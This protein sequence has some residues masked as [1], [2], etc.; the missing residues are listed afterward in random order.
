VHIAAADIERKVY[1]RLK[2]KQAVQG[3]LLEMIKK[4]QF[5]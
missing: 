3:L 5:A 2:N 4:E 1:E